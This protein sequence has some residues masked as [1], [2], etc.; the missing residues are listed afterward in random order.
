MKERFLLYLC[1][2]CSL[3]GILSLY[4]LSL[5]VS[6][7]SIEIGE[8][9]YDDINKYV[10]VRGVVESKYVT[11]AGHIF[12]KLRDQSGLIDVVIFANEALMLKRRGVRINEGDEITVIGQIDEY[13]GNL[14]IIVEDVKSTY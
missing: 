9:G 1:A 5:Q 2:G 7:E 13:K 10:Q 3:V 6:P 8:V 11:D 4:I 12:L 14:E